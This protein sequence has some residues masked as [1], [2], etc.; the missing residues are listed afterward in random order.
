MKLDIVKIPEGIL[1]QKAAPVKKV[2]P[3]LKQL[4][5]DML[6]TMVANDGI[7]LAAPQIGVGI[8]LFV[9]GLSRRRAA[10]GED[11]LTIPETILFN[12]EITS[13]SRAKVK[14]T[15]GCLSIPGLTGVVERPAAVTVTGLNEKGHKVTIAAEN[16]FARVIQH[17][18]DHLNGVLFTDRLEKYRV[19]FYGTSEFAV[20]ALE[21]LIKHPQ[22]EVVAVVTE[23]DKPAGRGHSLTASPVKMVAAKHSI[24]VLQPESFNTGSKDAHKANEA[25][26]A[27]H[28]LKDL[29]PDFQIVAS[30]GKI[31]PEEVLDIPTQLN[32]NIHP[33]LLPKYR[34]ATPIQSAIL[35]GETE[36]GICIIEMT[37]EMDAGP[38]INMYKYA[39]EPT[40][41]TGDLMHRLSRSA[42]HQVVMALEELLSDKAEAWMQDDRK[43]TYTEKIETEQTVIDWAKSTFQIANHIRAYSPKP[44]AYTEINGQTLKILKAHTD[45]DQLVIDLVQLPGKKPFTMNDLKNGHKALYQELQARTR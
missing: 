7:G 2:T 42:A 23:T 24:Q 10:E 19:V 25:K 45:D 28:T 16:L 20:P 6:Q 17:E 36:T 3:E 31:L 9:A 35:N 26:K 39:I 29:A 21:A 43:A 12:P 22:F 30:Y 34:G 5:K 33:S 8:R 38:V 13:K 41:T 1:R 15:E 14:M 27:I 40:E 11:D 18:I 44:G 32:L 37:A 4:A